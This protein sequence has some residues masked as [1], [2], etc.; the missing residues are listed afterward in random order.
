V[1]IEAAKY[2]GED[3]MANT[4]TVK[5]GDTLGKIAARLGTTVQALA[6]ANGIADVNKIRVGQVLTVPGGAP[7][8]PPASAAPPPPPPAG[9]TGDPFGPDNLLLVANEEFADHIKEAA[10]STGMTCQTVAAIIN[11]E[12]AKEK[13]GRW[14]PNSKASTSSASGLT[15][16][17]DATWRG[18]A[19]RRGGLLNTE[20]KALGVISASNA[21]VDDAKLM[22]LR[23]DPRLS[24]LAGADFARN[25]LAA[26]KAAGVIGSKVDPA[27]L[28]KL[29]YI[30]HHEGAPRAV[31]VLKGD[32][33]FVAAPLF[34]ANVPQSKRASFMANAGGNMGRAYRAWL[35]DYVDTNIVVT[36]FMKNKTGVAVPPVSSFFKG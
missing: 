15:Q 23:F 17:L 4:V 30:A 14:N 2:F 31:R 24:I 21:I 10:Q 22:R 11:A 16:F 32:M 20:A 9:G 3:I 8:P 12:A 13:S 28:A 26:M 19:K 6:E 29:A 5:S 36:K 1:L 34:N 33:G 35:A 25:N 27:G 18:E 7:A